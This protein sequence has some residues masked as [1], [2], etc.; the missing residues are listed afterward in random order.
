MTFEDLLKMLDSLLREPTQ[1]WNSFYSDRDKGVP[2]FA[3][4]PDLQFFQQMI[5]Q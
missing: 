4:S 5:I 2:F 3:N 1:F